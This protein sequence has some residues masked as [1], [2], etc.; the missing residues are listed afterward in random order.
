MVV[1]FFSPPHFHKLGLQNIGIELNILQ[2][3]VALPLTMTSVIK[4]IYYCLVTARLFYWIHVHLFITRGLFVIIGNKI[5][6][7]LLF[8]LCLCYPSLQ[9]RIIL[10]DFV[11]KTGKKLYPLLLTS[12]VS[13]ASYSGLCDYIVCIFH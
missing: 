4:I 1:C 6:F 2:L 3:C 5:V 12:N 13:T 11:V 8:L 10:G 7:R 9:L